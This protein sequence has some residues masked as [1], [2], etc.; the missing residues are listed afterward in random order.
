MND[1]FLRHSIFQIH[2]SLTIVFT[3]PLQG[4]TG[5]KERCHGAGAKAICVNH[6][7]EFEKHPAAD[8]YI[9]GDFN[10]TF[11]RV[12][13]PLLFHCPAFPFSL[14]SH[15]PE[16]SARFCAWPGFW[17]RETWEISPGPGSANLAEKLRETGFIK[18]IEV[19]DI[20]GLIGPRILCTLINEAAYT[21]AAGIAGRKD[22][23]TAMKLGT[24]YPLG[25]AEWCKKIGVAEV[26][27]VLQTMALENERYLPHPSIEDLAG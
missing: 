20:A 5:F 22:I 23:D 26:K 9:D 3:A 15:A 8:L 21:L 17:E 25:P 16:N 2:I 24:N 18:A 19:P 4:E 6:A 12:E 7:G 14:L 27:M 1:S 11:Y 13:A 10:G